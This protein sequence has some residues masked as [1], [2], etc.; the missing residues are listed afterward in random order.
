M[1]AEANARAS[2]VSGF[3]AWCLVVI[4]NHIYSFNNQVFHL[5]VS[6]YPHRYALI[7]FEVNFDLCDK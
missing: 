5:L 2:L 3:I 4:P 6:D 1:V 7:H